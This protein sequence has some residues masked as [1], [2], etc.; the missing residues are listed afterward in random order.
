MV[1][2]SGRLRLVAA[3]AFA[4]LFAR[5]VAAAPPLAITHVTVIDCTDAPPHAD[6]TVVIDSGRIVSIARD[7]S[8]PAGSRRVDGRGKYLIPGLWDM[9]VHWYDR[10]SLSLFLANGVTGIR[11]M[12]GSPD[13]VA[14][15]KSIE[16]SSAVG[17]HLVLAGPIVDGPHPV[18]P[19]S[20]IASDDSTGRAAVAK[21]IADGY[22][23]V[24]VY[25]LLPRDAYFAIADEARKRGVVFCG[26]VPNSVSAREAS[27]AGQKSI[28]HLTGV[29]LVCSSLEDSLRASMGPSPAS[30]GPAARARNECLL[31][32]YD[33]SK[34]AAL[35][36]RFRANGT[37]QCPTLTV[38]RA[39]AT[40]DS[41]G[42]APDD[43]LRYMTREIRDFWNPDSNRFVAANTAEDWR[44]A[45]RVFA[46]QV[47]IVR[48]MHTAHVPVIAGT[49]VLNP[50]CYPGFSLHDE[51]ALLVGA[52]LSPLEALQCAT[53][54]PARYLGTE[55]RRGTV[56]RGAEADLV[57]LD[58]NPLADIHNTTH[59]RAVVLRGQLFA[60]GDLDSMLAVV[61]A[62]AA[63]TLGP[64]KE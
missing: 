35:F 49:D 16:D 59:I 3:A 55:A 23:F 12:F 30:R 61:A 24:K 17:P 48:A 9:H 13:H 64:E 36:T 18:W 7:A 46:Q 25:S 5:P 39:Y 40:L 45:R 27:D 53:R 58:A 4:L 56:T 21:T 29:L 38:N 28:E 52:G 57:L 8:I 1:R 51:L 22:D 20:L 62:N 60:R 37:W 43:R 54:N 32:T 19:G 26:H 2:A 11:L 33:P 15:R 42:H 41:L 44:L 47:S 6:M 31:A 63:K 14:W 34:A 50:Y 10:E